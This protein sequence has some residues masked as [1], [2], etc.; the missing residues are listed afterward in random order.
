MAKAQDYYQILQVSKAA[1]IEEVKASFRRLARQ[2]HPDVNPNNVKAA[3]KFKEITQAYE[4]LSDASKRRRYDRNY[5]APSYSRSKADGKTISSQDFYFKGVKKS[6][7]KDYQGA[8][9]NYSQAI[10]L[11]SQYIEAYLK[12]CEARYKLGDDKGVLDDCY[13]ILKIN[14]KTAK[15]HYYQGRSRYRLGYAQAAIEAYT[16]A[17]AHDQNYAQAYYFRGLIHQ[18]F[19]KDPEALEDLKTAAQLFREQKNLSAYRVTIKALNKVDN[20]KLNLVNISKICQLFINIFKF[21]WLSFITFAFN[22][23]G[24]LL[25]AFS[26]MNTQEAIGVSFLYG[27]IADILFIFGSAAHASNFELSLSLL[28]F[29]G[30]VPFLCIAIINRLLRLIYRSSGSIAG[31]FFTAG[32]TLLPFG[33]LMIFWAI[34][35]NFLSIPA[36]ILLIFVFCYLVI[37]LYSSCTQISNF[38]ETISTFAVPAMLA[39]TFWI[40]YIVYM[41]LGI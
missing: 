1:S 22:P 37:T 38:S 40:S 6:L 5:Q 27:A 35:P 8:I 24:G 20:N 10:R 7:E 2:Y 18:E 14:N 34:I 26:K 29:L 12:R 4:V 28:G 11:N 41:L 33:F 9:E 16:E 39:A 17:I 30:A 3:E 32:V 25:P 13:Q 36:I 23:S 15:A 21:A 31:D 19:K